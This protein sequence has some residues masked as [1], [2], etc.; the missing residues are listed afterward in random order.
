MVN[1][2]YIKYI[3]EVVVY[4]SV[5][6][7]AEFFEDGGGEVKDDDGN[8][9]LEHRRLDLRGGGARFRLGVGRGWDGSEKGETGIGGR[10]EQVIELEG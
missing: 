3:V 2:R 8:D 6:G 7:E 9:E 1:Q 5:G 10:S 4:E